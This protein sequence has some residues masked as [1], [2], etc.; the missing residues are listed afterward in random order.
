MTCDS[1]AWASRVYDHDKRSA[2]IC[3]D[4]TIAGMGFDT[5]RAQEFAGRLRELE[6][7]A[8]QKLDH[9]CGYQ[10]PRGKSGGPGTNALQSAFFEKLRA[11]VFFISDLSRRPSLGVDA[12]R[13]Y[14]ACARPEL[15]EAALAVLE[16]RRARKIRSTYIEALIVE[17]DGRVHP[18]WQSY[19]AV[20]GRYS[21]S[22]PN[23]MNLPSIRVDPLA[24]EGGIRSL[25]LAS[26]GFELVCYDYAQQEMRLAAY[27]SGDEAMIAACEAADM[28]ARNSAS[29]FG[30]AFSEEGYLRGARMQEAGEPLDPAFLAQWK[31][32]KGLR[33]VAKSAGFAICYLAE[34]QTVYQ[35]IVATG[36]PVTLR[37][38]EGMLSG[39]RRKFAAYYA[40]QDLRLMQCIK[41]GFT[42]SPILGRRRWLGHEPSPTECANFP[43]Q[44]GAADVM[45]VALP[46]V[47]GRLREVSPKIRMVAQVH[48]SCVFEVPEAAVQDAMSEIRAVAKEPFI[49]STSGRPLECVLPID[50]DHARRWH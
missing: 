5:E 15:R 12:M 49:I 40:W 47:L 24:K 10:V 43:I 28:H 46:R 11:P 42:D 41:Q 31:T 30:A 14:A 50:L 35:R 48:D 45:A 38:V 33:N 7:S 34:A 13:G 20:S 16:W 4:M 9:A 19:G 36:T 44:G 17:A 23:L 18:N 26:E 2:E 6:A 1:W 25:Y 21:C 32:W 39:M 29:V 27:C 8:L 22:A 37:M 3:R